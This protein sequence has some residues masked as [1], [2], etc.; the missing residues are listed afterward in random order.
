MDEAKLFD[1]ALSASEIAALADRDGDG[2]NDADDAFPTDPTET[3]DT[4][5]DGIGDNADPFPNDVL[6]GIEALL[7]NPDLSAEARHRLEKARD[8]LLK[9]LDEIADGEIGKA[10]ERFSSVV[11]D[12]QKAQDE[13][14]E[15]AALI[16]R[17]VDTAQTQAQRHIDLA[18]LAC[19]AELDA[20]LQETCQA[21]VDMALEE[22][23]KA[24]DSLTANEPAKAI[25]H[26]SK[27]WDWADNA[28]N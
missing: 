6:E 16:D 27:A 22:V 7:D 12:L 26:Y 1:A 18:Q 11:K 17:L 10:L 15:V 13:G 3:V 14:V 23:G 25:D 8:D 4:D 28:Q 20:T 9:A 19:D 24:Q 2:V 5:G 21:N